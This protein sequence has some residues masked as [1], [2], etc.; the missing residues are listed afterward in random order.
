MIADF[1]SG[2]CQLRLQKGA[3]V[4][5]NKTA[6]IFRC[7]GRKPVL[8]TRTFVCILTRFLPFVKKEDLGGCMKKYGIV[9]LFVVIFFLCGAADAS[10]AEK[11]TL[12]V[13]LRYGSGALFSA[14]LLNEEGRGYEFGYFDA[15]RNFHAFGSTGE[16][17]ISIT[18]A[19]NIAVGRDGTYSSGTS[20]SG[21]TIGTYHVQLDGLCSDYDDAADRAAEYSGGYP[22]Y[23]SGGFAVRVG[24]Y[25]SRKDAE[26]AL[27]ELGVSGEVVSGSATGVVVTV[28]KT[29]DVLLE[30]DCR[31][32][33]SLGILPDGR[34]DA[35]TWF[36]GYRYNGGFQ[37][38]RVTGGNLN[39]INVVDLED[40]V[41]G[42]LPHEM[43]GGWPEEALKA[44]AV[45]ARTFACRNTKHLSAYGFD[46]CNTT[47]CQVYNGCSGAAA[48]TDAA[49]EATAGECLYADGKLIEALYFSS[50]GGA[51][52]DSENVFGGATTYLVGKRD[53]YEAAVSIPDYAYSVS[54]TPEE[55]TWILQH[56]GYSIGT[57]ADAYVSEFTR[58]GN[59]SK[60]TFVDTDGKQLTLKGQ[61]ARSAFYS[62]TYHKSVR[63]MRFTING[64]DTGTAPD[65]GI[66]TGGYRVNDSGLLPSLDG[67][68]VISGTGTVKTYSGGTPYV[69]T[70]GGTKALSL[71]GS[72]VQNAAKSGNVVI[73]GTGNGHNVGMSQYGASAMAKQGY[74]YEDIL[75]F[76]YTDVTIR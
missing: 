53:P 51:T 68:S 65:P 76:Y 75:H 9:M 5:Y 37:Y 62:S 43:G 29:T 1:R 15:G 60:V 57:V 52:E 24:S 38:D 73:T 55:L 18:A 16:T 44:Q 32:A 67:V 40:Y 21:G 12:K 45:C 10:A 26:N 11:D 25:V 64:Q 42:V 56:S 72:S 14:N 70:A 23:L 36:K 13:G 39:V 2:F 31:G 59:V 71:S 20:G 48:S 33:E 46:V 4:Y 34:M 19:G 8:P 58:M 47:D 61:K 35:V 22:A 6:G 50:D 28:T 27:E 3:S 17:A 7:S 66:G 41:K 30:F 69:V 54:Y 74:G 49:V 63:S